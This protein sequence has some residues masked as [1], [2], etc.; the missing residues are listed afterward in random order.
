[1]LTLTFRKVPNDSEKLYSIVKCKICGEYN[2]IEIITG[3]KEMQHLHYDIEEQYSKQD[4]S[5]KQAN[6]RLEQIKNFR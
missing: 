2:L 4:F 3:L 1:L 6:I 5:L